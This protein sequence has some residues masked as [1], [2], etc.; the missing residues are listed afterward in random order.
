MNNDSK[1]NALSQ[2]VNLSRTWAN[3]LQAENIRL[4]KENGQLR[5][6]I[7]YLITK[8]NQAIYLLNK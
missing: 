5:G 3:E 1:Y 2:S 7:N 4:K 8:I 6:I